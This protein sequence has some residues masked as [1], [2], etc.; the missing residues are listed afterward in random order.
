MQRLQ[1]EFAAFPRP[2]WVLFFGSIINAVGG[3]LVFPFL[4]LYLRQR[5]DAPMTT[6]GFILT[7][8]SLAA[9]P[10]QLLGGELADRVGRRGMMVLSLVASG[11]TTLGFGLA[12]S[13]AA[14]LALAVLAGLTNTFYGPAAS[15]MVAD[16]VGPRERARAYGL[17]RVTN[18]FGFAFGPALG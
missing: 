7:A 15:A 14:F 18:N 9:F 11:L 13:L 4:S 12:G 3:G 1:R 17:L 10:G 5:L 6:V 2:Y 16:L 8:W